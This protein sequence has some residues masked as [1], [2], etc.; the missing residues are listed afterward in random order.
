MSPPPTDQ[1]RLARL[2]IAARVPEQPPLRVIAPAA[3]FGAAFETMFPRAARLTR[4]PSRNGLKGLAAG[5]SLR[6]AGNLAA[7]A[8]VRWMARAV[9]AHEEHQAALRRRLGRE[10]TEQESYDAWMS[11]RR[12]DQ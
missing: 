9:V 2:G 11:D 3:L 10:P 5:F 7:D 12:S 1:R 8:V 4:W 6:F